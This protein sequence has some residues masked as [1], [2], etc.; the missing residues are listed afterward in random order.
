MFELHHA[1]FELGLLPAAGGAVSH[2]RHRGRDWLRPASGTSPLDTAAFPLVP[3]SGRIGHAR[4][5]WQGRTIRLARNFHPEPHAIHG[6][7]WLM[8]WDVI[9]HQ[10]DQVTLVCQHVA[11]DPA[12]LWPWSWQAEQT[13]RLDRRGFSLDMRLTN[14]SDTPMPAGLGWH[15]Y[16][17]AQGA[18]IQVDAHTLWEVGH[19]KLP[20][21]PRAPRTTEDLRTGPAVSTLNLDTPFTTDALPV[22][23]SWPDMTLRLTMDRVLGTLVVYTP[24]GEAYFCAEPVSHVPDMVN[25]PE[26]ASE[27]GLIVLAPGATLSAGLRLER[28]EV[29]DPVLADGGF[30]TPVR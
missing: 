28:V 2:L 4:F 30:A 5:N 9:D 13:F 16:F 3:F 24:P 19:D 21:M 7:G 18:R 29:A 23:L 17:S 11:G 20:G 6:Q 22:T 25:L 27:T 14:R 1:G 26:P 15:P 12:N 8:P 10:S